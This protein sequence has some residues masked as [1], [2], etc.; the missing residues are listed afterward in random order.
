VARKTLYLIDGHGQIYRAYYAPFGALTAPTG[1]ST[2]AIHVFLQM[3]LNLLRDRK[4]DYLAVALDTSDETVFRKEIDP[5]YKAN[6]QPP[7]EDL[8]PQIDRIVSILELMK[9][10]ILRQPRFEA[11]DIL[12]TLSERHAGEDV[13]VFLVSRDKD[14][15]Q[16]LGDHVRMYDPMKDHDIDVSA[17][18]EEKGYGPDQAIEAQML[19]GDSTDNIKGVAGVGPKKAAQLL[20]QYGS[21]SAIIAHADELSPKLR[22][23]ILAFRDRAERVRQ[24]VTLQR[25]VPLSFDLKEADIHRFTPQAA[26]GVLRELGLN[27]L[28][29]RIGQPS[30]ASAAASKTEAAQEGQRESFQR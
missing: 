29:E 1:E 2:R 7:P 24:L 3:L 20:K 13:D 27:R 10:P 23:N 21:L 17:L 18:R 22:E 5:E 4:P 28:L 11:D 26:H 19:I 14:L 25:D 6:R 15:D 16:L 9:V 8:P 30:P 12:A